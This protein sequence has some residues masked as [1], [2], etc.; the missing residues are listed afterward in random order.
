MSLNRFLFHYQNY[1]EE[2]A[3]V[4]ERYQTTEQGLRVLCTAVCVA[5]ALLKGGLELS[6]VWLSQLL[7]LRHP[8][9]KCSATSCSRM[10][11]V[12]QQNQQRFVPFAL[13]TVLWPPPVTENKSNQFFSQWR[14]SSTLN[15]L[16]WMMILET[17]GVHQ[18]T[19]VAEHGF[20]N[21]YSDSWVFSPRVK[22]C[23]M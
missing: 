17:T 9:Q 19:K 11:S 22:V 10:K 3:A 2:D 12:R 21:K 1:I 4:S 7:I 23:S 15:K 5:G 6:F 14:H 13:L 18:H 8:R 16:F 20:S